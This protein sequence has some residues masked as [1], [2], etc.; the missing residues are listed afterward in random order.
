MQE[1][2][3]K[4]IEEEEQE[5]APKEK[6]N[7]FLRG[8][9][10]LFGGEVFIKFGERRVLKWLVIALLVGIVYIYNS[11]RIEKKSRE[12]QQMQQRIKKLQYEYVEMKSKRMNFSR[13][14]SLIKELKEEGIK[15][16]K[17]PPRKLV[18]QHTDE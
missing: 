6:S 1:E 13:Q 4:Y 9:R 18:K 16:S 10:H 5:V 15:A 17:V 11:Y 7:T 14:S 12:I 3:K 8:L 2:E